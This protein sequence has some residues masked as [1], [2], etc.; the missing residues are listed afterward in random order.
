MPRRTRGRIQAPERAP[1]RAPNTYPGPKFRKVYQKEFDIYEDNYKELITTIRNRFWKSLSIRSEVSV[2]PN[3]PTAHFV[4]AFTGYDDQ[5]TPMRIEVLVSVIRLYLIAYRNQPDGRWF[6]FNDIDCSNFFKMSISSGYADSDGVTTIASRARN[7]V[8]GNRTKLNMAIVNLAR[9]D[10]STFTD[11]KEAS[12]QYKQIAR[13]LL[14]LIQM[15]PEAIRFQPMLDHFVNNYDQND[16]QPVG[17]DRQR[18]QNLWGTISKDF[19]TS[20][21]LLCRDIVA[22]NPIPKDAESTVVI[23]YYK[24]TNQ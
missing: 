13:D 4:V 14:L 1:E 16:A 7:L 15:L 18:L 17:R 5:N 2:L 24:P 9:R 20:D 11:Q 10:P 8:V 22:G 23:Y 21:S 3:D 6:S 19:Q 12:L